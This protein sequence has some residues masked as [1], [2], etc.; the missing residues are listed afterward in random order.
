MTEFGDV[1]FKIPS[2]FAIAIF[3]SSY[4]FN[5]VKKTI[6]KCRGKVFPGVLKAGYHVKTNVEQWPTKIKLI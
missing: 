4:N 3:I 6:K 1:N 5:L 2:I